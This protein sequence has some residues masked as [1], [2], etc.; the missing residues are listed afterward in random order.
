MQYGAA[1]A[2]RFSVLLCGLATVLIQLRDNESVYLAPEKVLSTPTPPARMARAL[3]TF[4][5]I[6]TAIH[7]SQSLDDLAVSIL[8]LLFEAVPAERGAVVLFERWS[9]EPVSVY[10]WDR[11]SE[12]D[13]DIQ[14]T[15]SLVERAFEERVA[16][17]ANNTGPDAGSVLT[18]PLFGRDKPL[19]VI[20]LESRGALGSF[21]QDHLQLV[22]AAGVVAGAAI[23]NARYMEWLRAE[24]ERLNAEISVEHGMVGESARMRDVYQ[25]LHKV[26]RTDSTVLITG[27]SGTGKELAARAVHRCSSRCGKP[28]IA[29]NCAALAETLLESE[30]FGHEKGAFTGAVAQKK[31]KIEGAE[32]GTLFLDEIGELPLA[33]QAKLLRALQ[34]RQFERVGGT[35]PIEVNIRLIA[36]SNRDLRA[37]VNQGQFRPDLFYRLNVVAVELP[38]LRE[39]REDIPLL[40]TYFAGKHGARV[41]RPVAGISPEASACLLAYDWPGNVRELE[42]AIEHAVVLGAT[43]LIMPEDLPDVVLEAGPETPGRDESYRE[44]VRR[45]KK[46]QILR[47]LQ[48]AGGSYT[49]AARSLGVHPNYLHRLIRNLNLKETIRKGVVPEPRP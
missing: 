30:M 27:E 47:A 7:R 10:C 3:S 48:K 17:L 4:Y 19:G 24:N 22:T 15:R 5:K 40:A 42:N 41:K 46:E 9:P 23:E 16:V 12:A 43:E 36:A 35:R 21:E 39:R 25:F 37:A 49:E 33:L 34:E 28:F 14:V 45:E 18:A 20:H 31:G 32:G 29:I 1:Q 26:A 38:P 2:R 6:S 8:R 11:V 13:A 44:A